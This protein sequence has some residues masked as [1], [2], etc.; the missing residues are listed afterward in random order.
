MLKSADGGLRAVPFPIEDPE[1]I[2]S[3]RYY[4]P[5]H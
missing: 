2:P 5:E 4:D 3:Q 1:R